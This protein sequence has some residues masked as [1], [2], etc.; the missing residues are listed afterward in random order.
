MKTNP[1]GHEA[2][3]QYIY[4]YLPCLVGAKEHGEIDSDLFIVII[5][6]SLKMVL[7]E[8]LGLLFSK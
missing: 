7:K 2:Q 5:A 6:Y 8:Q 4:V 3:C 1:V